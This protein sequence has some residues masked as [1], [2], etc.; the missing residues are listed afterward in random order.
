VNDITLLC[1]SKRINNLIKDKAQRNAIKLLR[2]ANVYMQLE[3]QGTTDEQIEL[4]ITKVAEQLEKEMA[5]W[6]HAYVD[7]FLVNMNE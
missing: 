2:N 7:T 4:Q 1:P 6:A 5:K 3:E